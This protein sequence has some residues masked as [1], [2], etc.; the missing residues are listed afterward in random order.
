MKTKI[1]VTFLLY[2]L[3]NTIQAKEIKNALNE[4][5]SEPFGKVKIE[6]LCNML[7]ETNKKICLL[8]LRKYEEKDLK[9]IEEMFSDDIVLR[10]WKIRVEGKEKALKE[11]QKNFESVETLKIEVLS[12][13]E[14]ENTVAAE[15]KITIDNKEELYVVDVITINSDGKISSIRAFIGRGDN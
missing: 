9:G 7:N 8:Y 4:N 14:N 6:N 11:T 15:L 5:W 13:Y 1:L 3:T 10:D 12:M 2:S